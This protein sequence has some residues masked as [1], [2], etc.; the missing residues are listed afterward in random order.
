MT[1]YESYN[2]NRVLGAIKQSVDKE[3]RSKRIELAK[4]KAKRYVRAVH[5]QAKRTVRAIEKVM[6]KRF[7]NKQVLKEKNKVTI[8]ENQPVYSKDKSR[9]FK[10]AWKE[11]KRQLYFK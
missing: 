9:F 3:V 1:S 7:S 5:Y 10:E 6:P 11:E 2:D 4:L 8:V